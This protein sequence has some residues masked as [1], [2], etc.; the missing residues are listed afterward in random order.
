[1]TIERQEDCIH[2]AHARRPAG[3]W[4]TP[5]LRRY[6]LLAAACGFASGF[7]L[8]LS[9][10]QGQ[11]A[12]AAPPPA[13]GQSVASAR[14]NA[15]DAVM[16]RGLLKAR[17]QSDLSVQISARVASI[18][19]REG[20]SFRRRD[21]L[22]QFDCDLLD[23]DWRAANAAWKTKRLK[24]RSKQRLLA[25]QA[26]GRLDA[27]IAAA[28]AEQ[29]A[30]EARR[31]RLKVQQCKVRAPYDGWVVE[32]HVDIAET[33]P[34]GGKLLTIVKR[35]PLLAE[36]IVPAAWL[37]WLKPSQSFVFHVDGVGARLH[38]QVTRIGAVVDEVSQTARVYGVVETPPEQVK[39]G[40]AGQVEFLGARALS[41]RAR[42]KG[43]GGGA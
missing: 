6:L 41:E 28:E 11:A 27:A 36:M 4:R 26:A 20:A 40:M 14:A 31:A 3:P 32:R 16:V 5:G 10:A 7:M 38:G 33:P 21:V 35:G 12:E 30:A 37:K 39:P 43:K 1:M 9:G 18:P 17:A 34:P 29:A 19:K 2:H 22:L 25:Y 8:V 13:A 24:A 23:A 15:T 42:R